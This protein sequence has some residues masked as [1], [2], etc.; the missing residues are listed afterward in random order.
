MEE[1][2]QESDKDPQVETCLGQ[3]G[4][5]L[6]AMAATQGQGAMTAQQL[7][8]TVQ[9]LQANMQQAQQRELTLRQQVEQLTAGQ[10]DAQQREAALRQ[11]LDQVLNGQQQ[12][13]QAQA[14]QQQAAFQANVGAAFQELARSQN[15]LVQALRDRPDKKVTLV[16]NRGLAKPDRFLGEESNW[17]YWKTR[18]EAFITSVHP[19]MEAVLEWA[20]DFDTEITATEIKAAFG[21][22]NPTHQT[23]EDVEEISGQLYA[24]LQTL[25]EKEAFQ[26][27]RSAGKSQGLEAWRKLN[28]RFDPSTGGRRGAMLRA[29]LSPQKC[30]KLDHLWAAVETWEENVRQY[31]QRRRSDGT[32]QQ[33][34]SE[35]KVSI[36]EQLCPVEIERHL[37]L[38]RSR[39]SDYADV[40]AELVM[41]LETRL[42]H[43]LKLGDASGAHSASGG[44]PMD[45]GSFSRRAKARKA[46]EMARKVLRKASPAKDLDRPT[47]RAKG[48]VVDPKRPEF[49]TIATRSDTSRRIVGRP[50]EVLPTRI[51]SPRPR[52][53]QVANRRV[54]ETLKK[55]L[56]PNLWTLGSSALPCWR[57]GARTTSRWRRM[58]NRAALQLL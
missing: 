46:K 43:R 5:S 28:R 17:L 26:V 58:P 37:Q 11:Q 52:Q 14:Q 10:T 25:C 8:D 48:P 7:I 29:I 2:C 30:T 6:A 55:S 9:Q 49:A 44:D 15:D 51:N 42:G 50:V 34:D 40:R 45:V 57:N 20:E 19:K 12:Q 13:A 21:P 1:T 47:T 35:I 22:V 16:D 53:S 4:T 27:V 23:I 38:N 3:L 39:Y 36:L 56:K 33:L 24:I 41:F 54:L 32:R 31:E 18:M